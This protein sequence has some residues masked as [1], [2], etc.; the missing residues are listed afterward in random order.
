MESLMKA[1]GRRSSPKSRLN[2]VSTKPQLVLTKGLLTLAAILCP[3]KKLRSRIWGAWHSSGPLL[4]LSRISHSLASGILK[5]PPKP[6]GDLHL[7][8]CHLSPSVCPTRSWLS[9]QALLPGGKYYC[10][11]GHLFDPPES[12]FVEIST[13]SWSQWRCLRFS[14]HPIGFQS[15]RGHHAR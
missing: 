2:T 8:L 14:P 10:F 9:E 1:P 13:V 7:A 3:W 5:G 12:I 6:E 4:G 15:P 11:F